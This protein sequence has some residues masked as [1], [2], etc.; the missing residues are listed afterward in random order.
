MIKV[1]IVDDEVL[2]R[3]GVKSLI[4]W[5]DNDYELIGECENGQ[6]AL[7]LALKLKPDIIISD[8]KMP[9]MN[10]IELIK[11]AKENNLEAKFIMLSSYD[12]FDLVKEAMKEG[13]KDYLLKL[14]LEPEQLLKVLSEVRGEIL[15]KHKPLIEK[16]NEHEDISLLKN[17]FL[18]GLFHGEYNEPEIQQYLSL[19]KIMLQQYNLVCLIV[20]IDENNNGLQISDHMF[21][22]SITNII[23]ESIKNYGSGQ[24][25]FLPPDCY[26]IICSLNNNDYNHHETLIRMTNDM[27]E[28]IRNS[29]N[30][31]ISIGISKIYRG[32]KFIRQAYME[33]LEAVNSS[34][35]SFVGNITNY[36][37]IEQV[38]NKSVSALIDEDLCNLVAALK[39]G[40]ISYI[41]DSF[42]QLL[43]RLAQISTLSN[44]QLIGSSHIFLFVINDFIE[45]Y[46]LDPLLIWGE[47]GNQYFKMTE[48]SRNFDYTNWIKM[49]KINIL[50]VLSEEDKNNSIIIKTKQ[51]VKANIDKNITLT[52]IS[53]HLG[54]SASYFS[55][56]FSKEMG[57]GFVDYVTNEKMEIAKELIYS[58][59]MKMYE[60]AMGLGY[61]NA[62]YFSRVFKKT[63][64]ISPKEFKNGA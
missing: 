57:Q 63:V 12:D 23:S 31:S 18:R 58:T 59:N 7:E 39:S 64:G 16:I 42:D 36:E 35:N 40:E 15:T 32:F 19:Y 26:S 51:F 46:H 10:G 22:N 11:A 53:E 61:E 47:N 56:L 25:L 17:K 43:N 24:V 3:V 62:Y 20:K 41:T 21:I 28:F 48:N 8:I 54:L 27:Q 14:Q 44:K 9:L 50:K 38:D 1:L 29:L 37:D 6:S 33:S 55:R 60:I 4:P 49:V 52:T 5:H 30:V 2:A 34:S 45:K 13:A